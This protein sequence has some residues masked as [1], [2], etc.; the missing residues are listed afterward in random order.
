MSRQ[1]SFK[2]R[3]RFIQMGI[4]IASLRR[5]MGYSQEKFAE[6]VGISRS[7]L[8]NIEAPNLPYSFSLD[9]FFN[10]AEALDIDPADLINASIFP[11]KIIHKVKEKKE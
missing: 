8:S 3:D 11:D 2:N 1:V 9:V 10:I 7:Q 4:A 5:L 6:K